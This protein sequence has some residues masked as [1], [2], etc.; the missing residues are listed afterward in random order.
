MA[1][2]NS[3]DLYMER[4]TWKLSGHVRA[5]T[6]LVHGGDIQHTLDLIQRN[7]EGSFNS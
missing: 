7:P 6:G 4:A 1:T 2:D 5:N 3:K